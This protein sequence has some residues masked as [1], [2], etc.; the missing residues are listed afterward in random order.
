MY[1]EWLEYMVEAFFIPWEI[2]LDGSV[3]FQGEDPTD[4]GHI[5]IKQNQIDLV[6]CDTRSEDNRESSAED[7]VDSEDNREFSD[8]D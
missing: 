3:Y 8:E 6:L 7:C 4:R 5:N 2:E 1:V